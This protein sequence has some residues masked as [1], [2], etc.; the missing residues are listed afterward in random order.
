MP[1]PNEPNLQLIALNAMLPGLEMAAQAINDQLASIRRALGIQAPLAEAVPQL[2]AAEPVKEAKPV[3]NRN[4]SNARKEY[5]N[6]LS[7]YKRKQLQ[8]K[9]RTGKEA[10]E[11]K[12]QRELKKTSAPKQP[13]A[14]APNRMKSRDFL[15]QYMRA[16]GG[17]IAIA[18]IRKNHAQYAGA[19]TSETFYDTTIYTVLKQMTEQ[20]HL[21]KTAN[22]QYELLDKS[23]A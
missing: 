22:G 2:P 4:I 14:P 17:K 3:T 8:E 7:P 6:S 13:A 9:M 20:G 11:K 19:P 12:R 21:K 18:D 23:N 1:K 16:N 10:A 15:F 5:W